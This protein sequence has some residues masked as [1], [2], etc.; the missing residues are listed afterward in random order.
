MKDEKMILRSKNKWYALLV[1]F[2]H[3]VFCFLSGI[4]YAYNNDLKIDLPISNFESIF[5]HI[6]FGYFVYDLILISYTKYEKKILIYHHIL[7]MISYVYSIFYQ[8]Y[9]GV[10]MYIVFTGEITAPFNALREILPLMNK[11]IVTDKMC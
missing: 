9:G 7:T 5:V 1:T 3:G 8:R 6:T 10:V 2:L 4:I 11:K